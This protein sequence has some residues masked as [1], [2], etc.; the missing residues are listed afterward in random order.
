MGQPKVA[1]SIMVKMPSID[2]NTDI[3]T[4]N[5]KNIGIYLKSIIVVMTPFSYAI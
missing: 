1:N 4:I 5:N 2:V 3:N